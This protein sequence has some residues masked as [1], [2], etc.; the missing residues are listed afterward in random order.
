MAFY[1]DGLILKG[2]PFYKYSSREARV[3]LLIIHSFKT[4]QANY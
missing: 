4:L 3:K 1:K 2:Y